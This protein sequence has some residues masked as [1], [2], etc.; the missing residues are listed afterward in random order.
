MK[1][2]GR[3]SQ[4]HKCYKDMYKA[5]ISTQELE[6]KQI[7]MQRDVIKENHEPSLRQMNMFNNL[8]KLMSVKIQLAQNAKQPNQVGENN[9]LVL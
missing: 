8:K 9:R 5:K 3:L 1:G 2:N 4:D 7:K 6:I